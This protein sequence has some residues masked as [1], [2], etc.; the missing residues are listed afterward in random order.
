[1]HL[2][3]AGGFA[4]VADLPLT[5]TPCSQCSLPP[6]F[7]GGIEGGRIR[8]ES[9]TNITLNNFK[10]YALCRCRGIRPL[11]QSLHAPSCVGSPPLAD[12]AIPGRFSDIQSALAPLRI[13]TNHNK[14][15]PLHKQRGFFNLA[16]PGGFE[17]PSPP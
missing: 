10:T 9:P 1:M 7:I 8:F 3:G 11:R 13:P 6:Y 4:T 15:A 2:T 16:S 17:P 14:K 12:A 5:G